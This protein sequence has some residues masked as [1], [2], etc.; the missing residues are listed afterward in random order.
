MKIFRRNEIL[1]IGIILLA[2][3]IITFFNFRISLRRTRDTQRKEA[4]GIMV[5]GLVL[6]KK[7][8]GF[9]P[10]SSDDGKMLA[11]KGP[12][13]QINHLTRKITNFVACEWGKDSLANL[14]DPNY[15]LFLKV[16]PN[17]PTADKGFSYYYASNGKRFQIYGSLE[18]SD[19]D[20]YDP[21]IMSR[22]LKC[23][24]QICNFGQAY[25][26]AL[27]KSIQEYENELLKGT[28]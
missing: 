20:E 24:S 9:F 10:L 16:I 3:V 26:T 21:K 4:L 11:C 15:P 28:K 2:L 18:G 17:D 27:D 7:Q 22:G 25:D 19:E 12:E 5:D 23:G 6:Y 13:T 8:F 14:F 1:G